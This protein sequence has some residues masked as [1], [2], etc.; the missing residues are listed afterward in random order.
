MLAQGVTSVLNHLLDQAEWARSRLS[1]FAGRIARFDSPPFQMSFLICEGG[2][3]AASPPDQL[4]SVSIHVPLNALLQLPEGLDRFFSHASVEGSAEFA[5]ELSFVLRNLRWD[6]EEDLSALIGDVA[7]HRL[8]SAASHFVSW[9]N[10]GARN[11]SANL[12]EY[13]TY[14][15]PLLV[16]HAEFSELRA[17]IS[18]LIDTLN[19]CETRLLRLGRR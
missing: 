7:A 6:A 19:Q 15:N 13:V 1:P 18:A 14:E 10:Q 4:P 9:Q 8:V 12:T 16:N 11:L 3:V 5:T 17:G 2:N